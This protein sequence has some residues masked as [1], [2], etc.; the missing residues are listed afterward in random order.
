MRQTVNFSSFIDAF[1]DYGRGEQFS[2]HGL[3]A[4]YDYLEDFEMGMEEEI[5][6]DVIALCCEFMEYESLEAIKTDYQ[7]IDP[8][9]LKN[10]TTVIE[11]EGGGVIIQGF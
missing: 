5:E 10:H 1:N 11:V 7:D 3:R 9:D 8:D 4:L 6:L 2:Y